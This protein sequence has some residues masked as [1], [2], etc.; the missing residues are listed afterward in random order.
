MSITASPINDILSIDFNKYHE[1]ICVSSNAD[2][3]VKLWD[4]RS[5]GGIQ[6]PTPM[7]IFQGHE[8]PVRKIRF[9]PHFDNLFASVS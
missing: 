7:Q 2:K 1:M 3:A 5:V 6:E 8:Y 9:S 4:L